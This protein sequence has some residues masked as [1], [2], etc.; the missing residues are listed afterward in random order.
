MLNG[1]G[2]VLICLV[3]FGFVEFVVFGFFGVGWL[4]FLVNRELLL[5]SRCLVNVVCGVIFC[6]FCSLLRCFC[7]LLNLGLMFL[8]SWLVILLR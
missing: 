1:M 8:C 7:R 5:F 2:F 3:V 6:S 4:K